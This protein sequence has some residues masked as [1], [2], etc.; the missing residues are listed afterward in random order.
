M[1]AVASHIVD[2][3][4]PKQHAFPGFSPGKLFL[5]TWSTLCGASSRVDSRLAKPLPGDSVR[6]APRTL[7]ARATWRIR[8]AR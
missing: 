7:P 8:A 5:P 3:A 6:R 4:V 2:A 1:P